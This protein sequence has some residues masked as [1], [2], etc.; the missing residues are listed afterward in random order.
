MTQKHKVEKQIERI[1]ANR[2][3]GLWRTHPSFF[4]LSVYVAIDA[5]ISSVSFFSRE[6]NIGS[7]ANL[8]EVVPQP[9][10]AAMF[11]VVFTLMTFALVTKRNNLIRI[12]VSLNLIPLSMMVM[13]FILLAVDTGQ[14][15]LF[16][17]ASK[18]GIAAALSF[19]MLR[20]PFV[21]PL[22]ARHK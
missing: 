19:L 9:I 6:N 5:F 3:L 11:A 14:I 18:W 17:A 1:A 7:Y 16:V 21:N 15:G 22:S 2:N 8:F 12:A 4:Y 13:N 10:Y 20:E